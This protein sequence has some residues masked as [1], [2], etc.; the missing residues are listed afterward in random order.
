MT[1]GIDDS[2][3][4]ENPGGKCLTLDTVKSR[5]YPL[6][7]SP[8]NLAPPPH[9]PESAAKNHIKWNLDNWHPL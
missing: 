9:P 3:N 6:V 2:K 4:S 5:V 1:N 7:Y 8:S